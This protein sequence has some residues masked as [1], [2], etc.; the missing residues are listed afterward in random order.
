LRGWVVEIGQKHKE[1]VFDEKDGCYL[2]PATPRSWLPSFSANNEEIP[3]LSFASLF[4]QPGCEANRALVSA[5]FALL[6][7][8]NIQ[9]A[10]WIEWGAGYRNLTAAFATKLQSEFAASS[11]FDPAAVECLKINRDRFFQEVDCSQSNADSGID[12]S[13]KSFDLWI[14]DPPRSGFSKLLLS[15]QKIP[16]QPKYVLAYHCHE[17]GLSQD[18]ATLKDA[19]YRLKEW[20]CV[21]AFPATSHCEVVSLWTL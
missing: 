16:H 8:E 12:S 19:R 13:T 9:R 11:E 14:I 7:E 10:N 18:M 2:R 4:S 20:I 6:D 21:D 3:L 1:V 15:L 17:K 5:G